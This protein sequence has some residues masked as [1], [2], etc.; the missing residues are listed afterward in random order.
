MFGNILVSYLVS[1]FSEPSTW[2]GLVGIATAAGV[3]IT[4]D[5]TN[6]VVSIGL[7]TAGIIGVITRDAK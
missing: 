4:P 5:Q 3:T 2:R 7:A 1:R 6:A